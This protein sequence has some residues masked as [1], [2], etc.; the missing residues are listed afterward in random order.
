MRS[1][2]QAFG[3]IFL[4]AGV[5]GLVACQHVPAPKADTPV[6]VRWT[7]GWQ[8][9]VLP[10]K[11][12]TVY[13]AGMADGRWALHAQSERSAS[14][15]RRAVRSEPGQLGKV[16]FS[17]KVAS[18]LPEADVRHSD[19]EDAVVRVLLA[20]DG[21]P[22]RLSPRT[23]MMFDL[24]QSLSGEA[25]PFATLV[26]VWDPHAELDR[27]CSTSAATAFARSC[28]NRARRTWVNGAATSATCV[29]TTAA[30]SVR[31]P[32]HSSAW[33]S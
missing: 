21:D 1:I 4:L 26:Y 9:F 2:H 12:A 27:S 5:L 6:S 16:S 33:P 29:K 11:T 7:D 31:S 28:S 13:T 17:W 32:A 8:P 19:T 18:L 22:G 25:P 20:F 23:R 10:G 14:M 3:G 30:P 24:I 15:Y